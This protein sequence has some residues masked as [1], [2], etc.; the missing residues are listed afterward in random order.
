MVY[1]GIDGVRVIPW[2]WSLRQ[3]S[4]S[5]LMKVFLQWLSNLEAIANAGID[6]RGANKIKIWSRPSILSLR[7]RQLHAFL[8]VPFHNSSE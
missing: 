8:S 7:Q 5:V 2:Y 4:E 1:R 3:V 6:Y